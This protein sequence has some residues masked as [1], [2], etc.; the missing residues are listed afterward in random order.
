MYLFSLLLNNAYMKTINE[1]HREN[2]K[3]LVDEFK[4]V[5]AVAAMLGCSESQ[6]SQWLNASTN[7]GTGKPRGLRSSSTR[8]IEKACGKPTGWM[9]KEHSK[10]DLGATAAPQ[11]KM[12][13]LWVSVEEAEHLTNLRTSEPVGRGLI[14]DTGRSVKKIITPTTAENKG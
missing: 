1:I 2:L 11:E 8:R 3:A 7:S 9:D 13:Y 4:S 5:T 12:L 14:I 10:V 6:Y